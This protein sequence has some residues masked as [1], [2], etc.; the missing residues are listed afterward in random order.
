MTDP[1]QSA[2]ELFGEALHLP[3]ERRSA[4]LDRACHGAPELRR[5]IEAFLLENDR[6][7]SFLDKP[8][9][10]PV[11]NP[12]S[13]DTVPSA[14]TGQP[15]PQ[16]DH[17]LRPRFQSADVIANRFEVVRFIARG[18]MGEVYEVKDR[19]LQ[20]VNLALKIIRPETASDAG[21]ATRFE[22]EVILARRVT[23]PN[24][25]PIYDIFRCEQP[26]PSFSFLTMKLLR[27]E[28]VDNCLKK[29]GSLPSG[30]ALEICKQLLV[31][32]AALHDGGIIHRDLKPNNVMLEHSGERLLV[33]IMDFGLARPHEFES[34]TG[35]SFTIAGTVGYMAPELL[36]GQ[37]PS[38]ASDIFALGIVMHQV[39]TGERPAESRTD[40]AMVP[41]P[42]LRSMHAPVHLFRRLEISCPRTRK[43]EYA[44]LH[45]CDWRRAARRL[46][47]LRDS[48][49]VARRQS[50]PRRRRFLHSALQGW[51]PGS[52]RHL[53]RT[54][55]CRG[56]LHFPR[57]LKT[58]L[59]SATDRA[60]TFRAGG[61]Q[62]RW[63]RPAA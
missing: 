15:L 60:S 24:L 10:K 17:N 33:S 18:G 22:Q 23:H 2:E 46:A 39:L 13:A 26:A 21:S 44:H 16:A 62:P 11:T 42:A 19:F 54:H 63:R 27:G 55:L 57:N 38:K 20:G 35:M 9:L 14:R 34:A 47:L 25:C 59:S 58:G 53:A 5:M 52:P 45:R 7:G 37:P 32:V 43:S 31:G 30:E 4:F 49:H 8:L 36:R 28:T 6:L 56:K 40:S 48:F 50:G 51:R 41:L 29:T 12:D 61:C 3:P 1:K